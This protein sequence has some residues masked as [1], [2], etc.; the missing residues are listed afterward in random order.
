MS[1]QN[2]RILAIDPGVE[3]ACCLVEGDERFT[4]AFKG[5]GEMLD[6]LAK[7]A[8]GKIDFAVLE[9]VHSAPNNSA[10]SAFTFGMNKGWWSCW[11]A[12]HKITNRLVKPQ[13]WQKGIP[14][15]FAARKN[16]TTF[17]RTLAEEARRRYPHLN[18]P[19][20]IADS[21]LIADFAVRLWK[22]E[23]SVLRAE[24]REH[25]NAQF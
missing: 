9:D 1:L 17:K 19:I 4:Y 24:K 23:G 5:Y 22:S 14:G 21:V 10:R 13:V 7:L 25:A 2:P 11:L 18:L 8:P 12:I 20:K 3:G 16:R 15:L 6:E